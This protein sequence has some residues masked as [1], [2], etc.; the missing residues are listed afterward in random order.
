MAAVWMG[1]NSQS[2]NNLT[3]SCKL[4]AAGE[5][6]NTRRDNHLLNLCSLRRAQERKKERER[7]R[8]RE[9]ERERVE[10]VM[11]EGGGNL[12]Y[13]TSSRCTCVSIAQGEEDYF[14]TALL[15]LFLRTFVS[16]PVPLSFSPSL[17][18]LSHSCFLYLTPPLS[19]HLSLFS[20][21][22]PKIHPN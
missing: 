15:S 1:T 2:G 13:S 6:H 11:G 10:D 14:L 7:E 9:R 19:L 5:K 17:V 20:V 21:F 18:S 12:W 4:G 16:L 3:G 8:K 22:A